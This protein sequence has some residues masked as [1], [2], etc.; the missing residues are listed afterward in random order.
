MKQVQFVS[1]ILSYF[2]I[3]IAIG[4]SIAHFIVGLNVN[5]IHHANKGKCR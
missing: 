5:V 3:A 2:L 1:S 4:G